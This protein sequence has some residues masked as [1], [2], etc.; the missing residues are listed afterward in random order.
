MFIPV[1]RKIS[2]R[3]KTKEATPKTPNW[4]GVNTLAKTAIFTKDKPLETTLNED[5]QETPLTAVFVYP[6]FSIEII[7]VLAL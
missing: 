6:I 7:P 2:K 1:S 5:I 3:V 4:E